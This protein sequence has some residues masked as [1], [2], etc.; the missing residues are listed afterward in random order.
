MMN[1]VLVVNSTNFFAYVFILLH[2]FL[3]DRGMDFSKRES[4][5]EQLN[6]ILEE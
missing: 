2:T 4:M 5:K 3:N 6:A 1:G